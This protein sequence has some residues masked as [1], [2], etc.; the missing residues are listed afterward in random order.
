MRSDTHFLKFATMAIEANDHCIGGDVK[1]K[2]A[3][4][5]F[6][7]TGDVMTIAAEQARDL[8]VLR[9]FIQSV[10]DLL[11][12]LLRRIRHEDTQLVGEQSVVAVHQVDC[13]LPIDEAE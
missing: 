10:V 11:Q 1:R 13:S 9:I 3:G 8:D 6:D 2:S 7:V 4:E 5:T 12:T